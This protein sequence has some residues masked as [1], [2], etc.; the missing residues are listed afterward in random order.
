MFVSR[1]YP[2]PSE[3]CH[4]FANTCGSRAS[5]TPFN[6]IRGLPYKTSAQKGEGGS[7]KSHQ[8][9]G[10]IVHN[11][12]DRGERVK[13]PNFLC[14]S[15]MEATLRNRSKRQFLFRDHR[16][17]F[18]PL[19]NGIAYLDCR[20]SLRLTNTNYGSSRVTITSECT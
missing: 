15:Y 17:A 1:D 4:L 13:N 5:K 14:M 3:S 10:Q 6:Y 19:I 2:H 8:I 9:C 18:D 7:S 20:P 12:A 16:F 11:Y